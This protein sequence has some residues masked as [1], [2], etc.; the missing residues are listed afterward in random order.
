MNAEQQDPAMSEQN[1]ILVMGVTGSGKSRFIN[2]LVHGAVR[3]YGDL[4]SGGCRQPSCMPHHM[5]M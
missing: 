5:L 1:M 3:E 2:T 4:H